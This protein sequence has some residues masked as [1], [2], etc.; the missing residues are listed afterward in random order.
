ME[1]NDASLRACE[2][3][4]AVSAEAAASS[5]AALELQASEWK[6]RTDEAAA[7]HEASVGQLTVQIDRLRANDKASSD[8]VAALL[9]E[10][11]GATL[12]LAAVRSQH[13]IELEEQSTNHRLQCSQL[14]DALRDAQAAKARTL[15]DLQIT[16]SHNDACRAE[17]ECLRREIERGVAKLEQATIAHDEE[18]KHLADLHRT[19]LHAA[20]LEAAQEHEQ[21]LETVKAE[22]SAAAAR[23]LDAQLRRL[24]NEHESAIVTL[25]RC[26]DDERA[27][28]VSIDSQMQR[29]QAQHSEDLQRAAAA[30]QATLEAAV[31]EAK[32]A[33]E[34]ALQALRLSLVQTVEAS[35]KTDVRR[36]LDDAQQRV[37]SAEEKARRIA[38]EAERAAADF[39][40]QLNDV[41]VSGAQALAGQ[42]QELE[43]DFEARLRLFAAQQAAV[44]DVKLRQIAQR[45]AEA[46]ADL[47]AELEAQHRAQCSQLTRECEEHKEDALAQQRAEFDAHVEGLRAA[48]AARVDRLMFDH[49][50]KLDAVRKDL[51]DHLA[52]QV[53]RNVEEIA[54]QR[55]NDTLG[56]ALVGRS[57]ALQAQAA[58]RRLSTKDS[59]VSVNGSPRFEGA[60]EAEGLRIALDAAHA[61]LQQLKS[62]SESTL[63]DLQAAHEFTLTS[64]R[65]Q[66]E[67]EMAGVVAEA[68]SAHESDKNRLRESCAKEHAA[69]MAAATSQHGVQIALL[70]RRVQTAEEKAA[71]ADAACAAFVVQLDVAARA[72]AEKEQL[73][74]ERAGAS[75]RAFT[76]TTEQLHAAGIRFTECDDELRRLRTECALLQ[77]AVQDERRVRDAVVADLENRLQ[78]EYSLQDARDAAANALRQEQAALLSAASRASSALEDDV[79]RVTAELQRVQDEYRVLKDE[80]TM[81]QREV[82]AARLACLSR[83]ATIDDQR[84]MIAALQTSLEVAKQEQRKAHVA[85]E[86]AHTELRVLRDAHDAELTR[87]RGGHAG[88]QAADLAAALQLAKTHEAR[89]VSKVAELREMAERQ[90]AL[91]EQ[92]H[93]AELER[94]ARDHEDEMFALRAEHDGLLLARQADYDARGQGLLDRATALQARVRMREVPAAKLAS[95]S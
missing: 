8:Q 68:M 29:L 49:S 40:S 5:K 93:G 52:L 7:E 75:D 81:I 36:V 95:T 20:A 84:S 94:L 4:L 15:E 18:V 24:A 57:A 42:Q 37:V 56:D 27:H 2:A 11:D 22:L 54:R 21:A 91:Q 61:S 35:Q 1:Q 50:E 33:G 26:L 32:A 86:A 63:R 72:A 85:V 76:D 67:E 66:L 3:L 13:A 38:E 83:E 69:A 59:R 9:A 25:R 87:I 64:L 89:Y 60:S 48:E 28:S 58:A 70:E 80:N 55:A 12:Q 31:K 53:E 51:A 23:D 10:R 39:K 73:L 92:K 62:A 47:R 6:K 74:Y 88:K 90:L 71:A 16:Q 19:E 79:T 77:A 43:H 45:H 30:H 78:S 82:D 41:M 46:L 44:H 65:I 34:L 17:I 14:E